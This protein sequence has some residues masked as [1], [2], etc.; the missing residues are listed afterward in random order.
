MP[1]CLYSA[2]FGLNG[3]GFPINNK[4]RDPRGLALIDGEMVRDAVRRPSIE[5][6]ELRDGQTSHDNPP[7]SGASQ[8][9]PE[10]VTVYLIYTTGSG[11]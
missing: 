2:S 8:L 11:G 3:G 9:P 1:V 6:L 5:I 10:Y 4:R 7:P